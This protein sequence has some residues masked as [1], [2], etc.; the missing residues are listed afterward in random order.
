MEATANVRGQFVLTTFR[1]AFGIERVEFVGN[2]KELHY[3]FHLHLFILSYFMLINSWHI[4]H[5]YNII[6]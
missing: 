6:I 3:G 2:Y 5:Y 4:M 1:T